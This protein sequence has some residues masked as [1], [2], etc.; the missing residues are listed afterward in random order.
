[1]ALQRNDVGAKLKL[2]GATK[3]RAFELPKSEPEMKKL[4]I[5]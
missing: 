3:R 1:M 2:D 5:V 4:R